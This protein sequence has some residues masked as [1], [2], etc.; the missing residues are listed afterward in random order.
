MKSIYMQLII[1]FIN[2]RL[3]NLTPYE[4]WINW[5]HYK[6][7]NM[8]VATHSATHITKNAQSMTL[9]YGVSINGRNVDS[10]GHM[11]SIYNEYGNLIHSFAF[12]ETNDTPKVDAQPPNE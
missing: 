7:F 8:E 6:L 10:P 5:D 11:A 12:D 4:C 3:N 9:L 1:K 2:L